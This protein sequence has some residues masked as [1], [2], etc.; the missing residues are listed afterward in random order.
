[1][2]A[3]G[4]PSEKAVEKALGRYI[5]LLD[6]S[7]GKPRFTKKDIAEKLSKS[8]DQPITRQMVERWLHPDPDKR[9]QALHGTGILL[10]R[11]LENLYQK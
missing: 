8:T 2:Q 11:L 6:A 9:T 10:V 3:K 4:T 5:K 7:N 1:M